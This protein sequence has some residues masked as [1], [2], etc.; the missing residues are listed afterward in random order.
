MPNRRVKKT[1]SDAEAMKTGIKFEKTVT[2]RG[3]NLKKRVT[4]SPSGTVT[5]TK[6]SK[7]SGTYLRN[8]Q[9]AEE[10]MPMMKR[11]GKSKA[12]TTT[13]KYAKGGMKSSTS[14][15]K[16]AKGGTKTSTT[17]KKCGM[18]KCKC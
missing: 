2:G 3:G 9:A 8:P 1:Y 4:V 13:K 15:K 7:A 18:K 6:Y 11:G 10:D 14:C 12:K 5:K 16:Y 17:C